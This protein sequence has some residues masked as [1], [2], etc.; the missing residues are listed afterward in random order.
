MSAMK[1]TPGVQALMAKL[2]IEMEDKIIHVADG[3][4]LTHDE[5]TTAPTEPTEAD[6]LRSTQEEI[7]DEAS[8]DYEMALINPADYVVKDYVKPKWGEFFYDLWPKVDDMA[9]TILGGPRGTGKTLASIM[10]A[11]YNGHK[12]MVLCNCN[13]EMSAEKLLG[14]KRLDLKG[15]GG[16][17]WQ[18]GPVMLAA[19]F[20]CPLVLDEFNSTGP[21]TQIVMNPLADGVQKGILIP[22]TGERLKWHNPR[23]MVCVNEGYAG[24]RQIQEAFRDRAE[25]VITD[26][27]EVSDEANLLSGR[28]NLAYYDCEHA[29]TTAFAI[30]QAAKGKGVADG[31]EVMPLTFDLSPRA[32]YSYCT[33]VQLGQEKS[34]AWKEAVI[35]RMGYSFATETT[36]KT[37]M[38]ISKDVGGFDFTGMD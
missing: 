30:R 13:P 9:C 11:Y 17:Y 35:D 10:W 31:E 37:V 6:D 28:T 22:A 36:R 32:L 3:D 2:G 34:K 27:L 8:G 18:P 26:Y 7:Q 15:K 25:P 12:K 21:G 5:I 19:M 20:D 24:T 33:R 23:I 4:G 29:C 16:D 14:C 1:L 38:Q